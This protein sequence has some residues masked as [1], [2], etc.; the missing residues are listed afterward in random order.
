MRILVIFLAISFT[1]NTLTAQSK[2]KAKDLEGTWKMVI[3]VD[4]E[5][6]LKELEEDGDDGYWERLIV[7]SVSG[8]VENIIESIDI[9]LRFLENQKLE[10]I[11]DVPIDDKHELEYSTWEIDRHGALYLGDNDKI[12]IN[13]DDDHIWLR[14]GDRLIM[15]DPDGKEL[16]EMPVYLE[17]ID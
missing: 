2:V 5:T 1:S 15:Y 7:R 8:L 6:I 12:E 17:R 11:A 3:D 14:K 4:E 10:I 16:E 9:E 13:G